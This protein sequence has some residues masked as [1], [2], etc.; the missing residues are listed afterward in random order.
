MRQSYLISY[1]DLKSIKLQSIF[2]IALG[3]MLLTSITASAQTS[4]SG[5]VKS[6][7]K[8]QNSGLPGARIYWLGTT[9][10][11]IATEGGKFELP[12]VAGKNEL[13]VSFTGFE[14]DTI[15]VNSS[16]REL[17]VLLLKSY[18]L[19]EIVVEGKK[20]TTSINRSSIVRQETISERGLQKAACCNLAE[21]F[22]TNAAVDVA[23]TDAV[24]GARKV[25]LLGLDGK[26]S[27]IM[28]ENIPTVRGLAQMY[29]MNY[30]PG[31]W[32][33]SISISKGAS[34]VRNGFE[35]ITGQ[36]NVEYKKPLQTLDRAFINLFANDMGRFE[37]NMNGKYDVG[38]NLST[39]LFL[40]GSVMQNEM[41][42]NGDSFTDHPIANQINL[43]NYWDYSGESSESKS[44]VKALIDQRGGGQVG[45]ESNPDL[46]GIDVRTSRVELFT[47]NGFIFEP[48]QKLVT[49]HEGHDHAETEEIDHSGHDH[50]PGKTHE[51]EFEEEEFITLNHSLGTILNF[52]H[53]N[54]ESRYGRRNYDAEQNS[55]YANLIYDRDLSE[56]FK[57]TGGGSLQYDNYLENVDSIQLNTMEVIPG[58]F[59]ELTYQIT[60]NASITGGLRADN[61][62]KFGT[63]VTP[64]LHAR[65]EPVDGL[66][67]RGSAGKGYRTANIFAENTQLLVSSRQFVIAD[68]LEM[69]EAWNYGI[70]SMYQFDFSY[71]YF[72][73]TMDFYRT[74]FIN[75]VITDLD[76]RSSEAR[77]YNLD[78]ES[79]SNSFQTDLIAEIGSNFTFTTAYRYNDVKQTYNGELRSKP[80]I[81]AHKGFV[82]M[83]YATDS[84]SWR[85]DFTTSIHG[86]GRLPD[87]GD[88]PEQY[89]REDE[90]PTFVIFDAQITKRFG[91]LD[92]Y[93]GGENLGDYIQ[94]NPIIAHDQPF[95]EYFDSSMIWA[96][97]QG[98]KI[99]AGIRY[100]IF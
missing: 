96:P 52:A 97:V 24:S 88:K 77:F 18:G 22:V 61:H 82:N 63:F 80:L 45:Y 71:F 28:T 17:D 42:H 59:T 46:Y 6:S 53:H 3:L 19:S 93:I 65:Y 55:L 13:V 70:S 60:E 69:E 87:T 38:D 11:T 68:D 62:N 47:K 33:E 35:S 14:S 51:D 81:S 16:L 10:G 72:T 2:S 75:Q 40:H 57:F 9:T 78:G 49:D 92:F 98:R 84:D 86:A 91:N 94:P 15:F 100:S 73:W 58:V 95:S 76:T 31:S 89:Q 74:D 36:I 64:R 66:I 29:G 21:S 99:Y 85:I 44:G 67:F 41:D 50:A 1:L 83:E 90:F 79:Y 8:E 27:Q 37:A 54:Q 30:I 34:S 48:R 4:I 23:E 26:Y 43:I 39:I 20:Q 5:T 12:R 25:K 7:E 32:M 56:S